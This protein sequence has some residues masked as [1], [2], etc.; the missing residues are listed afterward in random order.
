MITLKT[1]EQ[2]KKKQ[3]DLH[4]ENRAGY[5]F[6]APAILGLLIF[7]IIPMIVS[8]ILSFTDYNVIGDF[9][10]TGI[11]NYRTIFMDDL[12]SKNRWL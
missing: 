7:T 1:D 9:K 6:A 2:S 5:A 10:F 4:K 11:D 3:Y 8:L 12:F